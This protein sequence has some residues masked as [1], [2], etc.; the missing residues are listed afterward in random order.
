MGSTAA[1]TGGHWSS[2]G[3]HQDSIS[4][5]AL[6]PASP[7]TL[8]AGIPADLARIT[9]APPE[10]CVSGPETLCLNGGRFRVEA[11]WRGALYSGGGVSPSAGGV[12]QASPITDDTGS[13]WFFDTA[14]LELVVKVLDGGGVNGDFWVFY[15]GLTNLEYIITVT[16]TEAGIIQSYYN[17]G[18]TY[19]PANAPCPL[20]SVADTEAFPGASATASSALVTSPAAPVASAAA[21]AGPCVSDAQ[22]LCEL[23]GRFQVRV[24]FQGSPSGPTQA[25]SAVSLTDDTGYFWFFD[26]ANIEVVVKTLDGTSINGH[27]WV[28]SGALSNVQYAITVTDLETGAVQTYENPFGQLAGFADTLAF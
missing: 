28:F 18:G 10:Q 17:V 9:L 20:A 24:E 12:G 23:D 11:V 15:G 22:T 26:A 13:F 7:S 16:D 5:L 4:S 8:Y 21:A 19:C 3:F 14:N 6:D 2:F 27:Y 1:W 25:A